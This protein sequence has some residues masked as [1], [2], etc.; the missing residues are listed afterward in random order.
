[1]HGLSATSTMPA[2]MCASVRPSP[3]APGRT[4]P[5]PRCAICALSVCL[6]RS[7]LLSSPYMVV[8]PM[9]GPGSLQPGRPSTCVRC[10]ALPTAINGLQW[11]FLAV[12]LLPVVVVVWGVLALA[13]AD[14]WGTIAPLMLP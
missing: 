14:H 10:T 12:H 9:P 11:H 3:S 8:L 7:F 2:A 5:R 13:F 4:R 1:M 6:R